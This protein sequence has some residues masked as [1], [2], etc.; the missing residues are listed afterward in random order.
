MASV[1]ASP[2][3]RARAVTQPRRR[4]DVVIRGG[5]IHDGTLRPPV[6]GD[7]ALGQGRVLAAGDLSAWSA[8]RSIEAAGRVVA[9]GFID[10]HSHAAESLTRRG[11][12]RA[13]ALLAQG[14][15]T[16]VINPDGGGPVDLDVQRTRMRAL[17]LGVNVAPL[18]GH[19]AIRGRVLGTA[20][21]RSH[22]P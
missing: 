18:V 20:Q 6:M 7:V 12:H 9:P 14:I 16:V 4:A 10:A 5:L 11:L 22:R 3:Q 17:G 15:T 1:G 19:G 2:Q 8:V 21:A 13:E